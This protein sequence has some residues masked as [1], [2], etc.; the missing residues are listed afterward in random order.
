M[1]ELAVE[2]RGS[3]G[4]FYKAFVKDVQ[5]EKLTVAFENNWQPERQ[6]AFQDAR[7]PPPAGD[8]GREITE[9]SDVEVFSRANE[10]EPCGWWL[11]RVRM[12]KGDFFVIEYAVCEAAFSEIVTLERLRHLNPSQPL[13]ASTFT[14]VEISVP[15]DIRHACESEELHRDFLKAVGAQSVSFNST[16]GSLTILARDASV[17][18]RVDM[19]SDIHFRGIRTKLLLKTSNQEASRQLE[20]RRRLARACVLELRVSEHLLGLAVGAHEANLEA[21]RGLGGVSAVETQPTGFRIYGETQEAVNKARALL[22]FV[23][24]A[25]PV[26]RHLVGKVIGKGGANIQEMVDKSGVVRVRVEG[27]SERS[28]GV[29]HHGGATQPRQGL[30]PFVFVGTKENVANA[31]VLLSY[32]VT[33]LQELESLRLERLKIAEELRQINVGGSPVG[34]AMAVGGGPCW[35]GVGGRGRPPPTAGPRGAAGRTRRWTRRRRTSEE[36]EEEVEEGTR[37]TRV[38]APRPPRRR[39]RRGRPRLRSATLPAL[40]RR[41]PRVA[42][43]ARPAQS[44][45][46]GRWR[47][48]RVM[49]G[50]GWRRGRRR[51]RGQ[52]RG[53]EA[54]AAD[55][56]EVAPRGG[57]RVGG[58][59]PLIGEG[60]GMGRRDQELPLSPV[61]LPTQMH[62]WVF[63]PQ[64]LRHCVRLLS[65]P[66]PPGYPTAQRRRSLDRG[67]PPPRSRGGPPTRRPPRGR[68]DGGGE[69]AAVGAR[70]P[71]TGP[72]AT[73]TARSSGGES[74]DGEGE[75]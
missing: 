63:H 20:A 22:E 67:P 45:V 14:R 12:I 43:S 6:V 30:V 65:H 31:K 70:P 18:R 37:R 36:E 26:P 29:H 49:R 41:G 72:G 35:W 4:A 23:E 38:R 47:P 19:L 64:M 56:P 53:P 46:I 55:W 33:Y 51:G 39:R 61:N 62:V 57:A 1:E 58:R 21:A 44:S 27:D 32:H 48:W 13:T 54:A 68:G 2:V 73:L 60:V 7:L 24:E 71:A 9:N 5:E 10:Q 8:D 28:G 16:Q 74:G 69:G 34:G 17:S 3:N 25:V 15:E 42:G 50:R 52:R 75:W 40:G 66:R 59:G 11:A